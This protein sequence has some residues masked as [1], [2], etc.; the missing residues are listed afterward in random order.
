VQA[1]LGYSV[2][3]NPSNGNFTISFSHQYASVDVELLSSTGASI[4]KFALKNTSGMKK[5]F[6]GAHLAKGI[7]FLKV[8]ADNLFDVRTVVVE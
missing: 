1:D 7:Y 8:S 3:P 6:S 2:Y 4:E 5:T